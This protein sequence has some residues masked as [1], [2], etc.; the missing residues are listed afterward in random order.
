V[1]DAPQFVLPVTVGG[2]GKFV[3]A[4]TAPEKRN[5]SA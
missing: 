2:K 5:T 4:E 3:H 1:I